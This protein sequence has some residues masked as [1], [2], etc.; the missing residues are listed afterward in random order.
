MAKE[1]EPIDAETTQ[2]NVSQ[3]RHIKLNCI[4]L[5][6]FSNSNIPLPWQ[7]RTKTLKRQQ[8]QRYTSE[9]N[10]DVRNNTNNYRNIE[11]PYLLYVHILMQQNDMSTL[12][13]EDD[14]QQTQVSTTYDIQEITVRMLNKTTI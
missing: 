13:D 8:L 10:I 11:T 6:D 4:T 7:T 3:V 1:T 2:I 14:G 9:D 5:I 12:I